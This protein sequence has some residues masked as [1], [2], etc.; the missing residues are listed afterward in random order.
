MQMNDFKCSTLEFYTQHSI[1][2]M[3]SMVSQYNA[4]AFILDNS[5]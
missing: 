3:D 2:V 5:S 1:F 4:N